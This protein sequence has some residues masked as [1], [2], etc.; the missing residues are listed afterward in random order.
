MKNDNKKVDGE[1]ILFQ[2]IND[3][4]KNEKIH[5][6]WKKYGVIAMIILVAA[7]TFVVSFESIKAW[8]MKKAATWTDAYTYAFNLQTQGKYDESLAIFEDIEKSNNGIYK[9]LAKMQI[10]NIWIEQGKTNEA[11]SA[12]EDVA[13]DKSFN[14]NLRDAAI[15]KLASYKM[16]NAPAAEIDDLL[17]PLIAENSS[18]SDMALEMKAMVLIRDGNIE[19]AKEAYNELLGRD[20]LDDGLKVRIQDMLSVLNEVQPNTTK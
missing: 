4:L 14:E 15:I 20:K 12:M 11:I 3:E 13:K 18:W 17:N 6:F 1:E 8:Q 16:D 9:D 7:L 19:A 5:K 2:E 10:I